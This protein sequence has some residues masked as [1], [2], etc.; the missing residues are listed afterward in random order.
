[1]DKDF[2]F[3]WDGANHPEGPWHHLEVLEVRGREAISTLYAFEIELVRRGESTEIDV[4]DLVGRQAALRMRTETTPEFRIVHGLI[5]SAVELG[6]TKDGTR[7]RLTIV[8]PFFRAT[9][10]KKSLIYLEKTLRDIISSVLERTAWGAGLT[11]SAATNGKFPAG[12]D[13]NEESYR[14]AK[15]TYLWAVRDFTRLMDKEARPYCVQYQ[16]TDFDFVSRL[17]EE[18]GISYHFEQT[19]DECILVLTDNDDARP[20]VPA[21]NPL[22]PKIK[23]RECDAIQVGARVRPKAASLGDWNWRKPDLELIANSPAGVTDFQV[24]EHPGRFEHSKETGELLAKTMEQRFDTER[25]W[26]SGEFRCRLIS[27]GTIFR[28]EHPNS[29]FSGNYLVTKIEHQAAEGGSFG[30]NGKSLPYVAQFEAIRCGTSDKA[31]ESNFRPARSTHRPRIM[32]SQTAIVTAEPSATDAEIN[33]GGPENIGCVRVRFHWDADAGR[34]DKEA[35]SCWIRVSHLFAGGRGHGGVFHPRVGDEVIVD[36]L[37]GDPDRPL[38][39]GRVYNGVNLTP[40][41]AT[42]R[43]TYSAIKTFSSPF[44]GNYNMISFEDKQGEEELHVHAAR[45]HITEVERN[46]DRT[47]GV[48]DATKVG[49]NQSIGVTGSQSTSA[50]SI[51]MSSGSTVDINAKT[52]VT[53]V[54]G[55]NLNGRAPN[56]TLSA[57]TFVGSAGGNMVHGAGSNNTITAGSNLTLGAPVIDV[58][59]EGNVNVGAPWIDIKG[60]AK[61]R[62]GAGIVEVNGATV[63]VNGSSVAVNGDTTIKGGTVNV[64][65]G[66]VN[67]KGTVKMNC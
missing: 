62:I 44:N 6:D 61:V 41:N 27:A 35:T 64:E 29:R 60:G 58:N 26:A 57:D 50:G 4:G 36:F 46:S 56:I 52:D 16:E 7:Y 14:P 40:E 37:E 39:T 49:G 2:T 53:I 23:G 42:N 12:D 15:P 13:G 59:G 55:A 28:L 30:G 17:L 67:I 18:E 20:H 45:D 21:N 32:G 65:A 3:S 11:K 22:G 54:G 34:H 19:K 8:P 1:M 48:D 66:T 10:M 5:G 24:Y 47:V 9:M 25:Q 51:S 33:V 31:A 63:I 43:P 38:V